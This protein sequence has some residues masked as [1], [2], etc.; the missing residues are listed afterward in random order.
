M[1]DQSDSTSQPAAG[2][3]W[4]LRRLTGIGA[5]VVIALVVGSA[6]LRNPSPTDYR[7]AGTPQPLPAPGALQP[8]SRAQFDGILIGQQPKPVVVNVWASWCAPC[9][10]EAPALV[11]LSEL[12]PD[13]SFVGILTRD[14][15]PSARAFVK[16]FKIL[17][18]TLVDET[19]LL[20]FRNS[21]IA[22]AIPTTLVIDKN[23]KVAARIS[24]EI[25][26]AS[27]TDLI[28][29]VEAGN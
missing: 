26:V 3:S 28:N 13:V 8:V 17:Y 25:T 22:N 10:S 24:G 15:L 19:I 27:L 12:Y 20:S 2:R 4:G 29:K 14:N 6:A 16:R 9:R 5:M 1:S 11:A 21:L 18:P 23:G 7:A